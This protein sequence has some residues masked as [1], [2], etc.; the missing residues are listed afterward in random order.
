MRNRSVE[1]FWDRWADY[2][3]MICH[4]PVYQDF[5]AATLHEA[6][7]RGGEECLDLGCGPGFFS[8]GLARL[9]C[10]VD[11]VDYSSSMIQCAEDSIARH[12]SEYDADNYPIR[13]IHRDVHEYVVSRP[14]DSADVV[15]ASLLLSYLDGP[16][17]VV[18]EVFRILRP[19]GRF[20]M[21]NPVPDAR[22]ARIFWKSGWNAVRYLFYA[23]Q[24]LNY[25]R[26][27]KQ[28][29]RRGVFH[30]FTHQETVDLLVGAE[31]EESQI[32]ISL[33]YADTSFLARAVKK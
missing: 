7:I 27:I 6:T 9:G 17:R 8:I 15:V 30:F 33:T 12:K 21:S 29:E 3:K 1:H 25:A 32:G 4:S 2:Y 23:V 26:K 14:D 13:L 11:A 20:V 19:G 16:E 31:F 10:R 24:L 18:A 28:L 5:T 22:F